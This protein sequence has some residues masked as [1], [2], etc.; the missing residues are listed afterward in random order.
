MMILNSATVRDICVL[1]LKIKKIGKK[2]Y[3]RK[4]AN[5]DI[6]VEGNVGQDNKYDTS[7]QRYGFALLFG[8]KYVCHAKAA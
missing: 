6:S 7:K 3:K 2:H 8:I 4:H 1:L 5:K